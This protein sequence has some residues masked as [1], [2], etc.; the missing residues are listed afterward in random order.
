M[1]RSFTARGTHN[2]ID[3][4]QNLINGY[5]QTQHSST[6][7]KPDDV[8]KSNERAVRKK[9]FPKIKK[10]A[11][12][13]TAFF[14]VGDTVRITRKKS[15]FQKG[16][17]QTFSYEVFVVSKINLNT[18]PVT[19]GLRDYKGNEIRGSFYRNEIQQVDKSDN[20]WAIENIVDTRRVQGRVEYFVKWSGY[21][22]EA[23]AWIPHSDIF[24]I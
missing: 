4:L 21:P 24:N 16:Y 1:Y 2:W 8:K 14:K 3:I 18:Y 17:E 6:G 5:N 9:L 11:K 20:I 10:E 15:V 23:N 7:F 12:Y 19:Y 13:R 22:S